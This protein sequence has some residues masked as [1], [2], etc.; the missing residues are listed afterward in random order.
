M[1][2]DGWVGPRAEV[3]VAEGRAEEDA[4]RELGAAKGLRS[5][6]EWWV[7]SKRAGVV[8]RRTWF[9]KERAVACL[10]ARAQRPSSVPASC[11]GT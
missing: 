2:C 5:A 3:P 6:R 11:L 1:S 9:E 7:G 10:T 8:A 4:V